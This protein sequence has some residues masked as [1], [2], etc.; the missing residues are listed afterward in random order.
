MPTLAPAD[1]KTPA[2]SAAAATLKDTAYETISSLMIQ[3]ALKAGEPV[4]L[5]QAAEL[6]GLGLGPV[7]DAIFQLVA[8]GALQMLPNRTTVVPLLTRV[9]FDELYEVRCV[10]EGL[11]VSR[12]ALNIRSSELKAVRRHLG[13][14]LDAL[15]ARDLTHVL[16]SNRAF[17]FG[18]YNASGSHTLVKMIEGLWQRFGPTLMML[19]NAETLEREQFFRGTYDDHV[20]L[21]DALHDRNPEAARKHLVRM[22]TRSDELEYYSN[23]SSDYDGITYADIKIEEN[24]I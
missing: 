23:Q 9:E 11:A 20:G 16:Q 19:M 24:S 4:T 22:V 8:E 2:G 12:A 7:R 21:V 15:D 3:G 6:T 1:P 18:I 5:R 10:L 14:L 17:Q 13:D